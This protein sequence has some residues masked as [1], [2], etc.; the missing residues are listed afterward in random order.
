MQRAQSI[1]F[2]LVAVNYLGLNF[3]S[4]VSMFRSSVDDG[5]L[6]EFFQLLTSTCFNAA[7]E[8]LGISRAA[9]IDF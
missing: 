7:I 4:T 1:L 9:E 3:T 6:S 8:R 5:V 2:V